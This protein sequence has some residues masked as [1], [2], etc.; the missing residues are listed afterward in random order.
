MPRK[1][2]LTWLT[3][4]LCF[5]ALVAGTLLFGDKHYYLVTAV[6]LVFACIPFALLFR[7]RRKRVRELVV[8]SVMTAIAVASRAVFYM[9]P[10]FKPLCAIAILSGIF[11]GEEV[12]FAVGA[13][14][15][16][17]SNFLFGQGMWTPFQVFGMGFTVF[18]ASLILR[19]G[20]LRQNR[21]VC[22]LVGG[23]LTFAVYGVIV[24]TCAVFSLAAAYTP[25]SILA[26]YLT[27]MPLNAIHGAVTAAVLFLLLRPIGEKLERMR[28]KYGLF[29]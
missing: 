26:V 11:L 6:M 7:T 16:F 2:A 10:E 29:E 12:G 5:A 9:I 13:L 23:V 22:A 27:G 19:R 15:M 4:I 14:A 25:R 20:T 18:L 28:I 24:D 17:L 8:A 1:H 3:S 21:I